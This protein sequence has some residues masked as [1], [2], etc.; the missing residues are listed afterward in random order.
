MRRA[1]VTEDLPARRVFREIDS[2]WDDD[3]KF[4]KDRNQGSFFVGV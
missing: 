3:W 2:S 1:G 4:E